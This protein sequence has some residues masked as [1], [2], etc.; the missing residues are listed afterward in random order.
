MNRDILCVMTIA[1]VSTQQDLDVAILVYNR[2]TDL[3][4]LLECLR[5][6]TT[7]PAQ[8]IVVDNGS[9]VPVCVDQQRY[10][11]TVKLIRIDINQ[12]ISAYNLAFEASRAHRI[13]VID[14][15]VLVAPTLVA[16]VA[17]AFLAND[18]VKIIGTRIVDAHTGQVMA[19]NPIHGDTELP[20]GGRAMVQFNGCCFAI[21]RKLFLDLGGFDRRLFIYVNEW[22]FCLR[23]FRVINYD[24]IRYYPSITVLHKTS[25]SVDR[26][27][28]YLA[29]IRRNELWVR[30]KYYPWSMAL[31]YLVRFLVGS[32]RRIIMGTGQPGGRIIFITA[33]SQGVAG[34]C[35]ALKERSPLVSTVFHYLMDMRT[36]C[37]PPENI[38]PSTL[39]T[40]R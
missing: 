31:D 40:K 18:K 34:L 12:G 36:R 14:S 32:V 23:A 3:L 28:L 27:T 9:D 22:D 5:L 30:F 37:T 8:V 13:I 4:S 39:A 6:Q 11:F 25:P 15:D 17:S 2:A 19:D 29:L 38:V 21:E 26:A 33:L 35:W 1:S 20:G 10:P 7:M 24:E 16:D